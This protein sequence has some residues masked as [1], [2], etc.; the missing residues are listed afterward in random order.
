VLEGDAQ[1]VVAV[2]NANEP[3]TSRY[4][5][6]VG[7]IKTFLHEFPNWECFYVSRNFNKDVQGLAQEACKRFIEKT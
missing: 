2:I 7:D 3:S 5:H 6:M 4:G 1:N